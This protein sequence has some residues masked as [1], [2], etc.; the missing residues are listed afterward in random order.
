[1]SCHGELFFSFFFTEREKKN[2]AQILFHHN[3]LISVYKNMSDCM[4]KH[5]E[6][7]VLISFASLRSAY[8]STIETLNYKQVRG[9]DQ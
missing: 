1:M 6:A 7:D 3:Y 9:S 8:E 5:P 2:H 4:Q